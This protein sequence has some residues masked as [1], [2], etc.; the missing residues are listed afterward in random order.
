VL[1]DGFDKP[2]GIARDGD[3]L[4]VSENGTGD[5]VAIDLGDGT[6]LGR[7]TVPEGGGVMGLE[8]GPDDGLLYYAHRS[9]IVA[10]VDP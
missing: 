5:I 8:I 10:R 9:G 6:E 1:A 2:S 7:I 3:V 4:F